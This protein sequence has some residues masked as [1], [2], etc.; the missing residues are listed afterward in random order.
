MAQ[1]SSHDPRSVAL[2]NLLGIG[3]CDRSVRVPIPFE[4]FTARSDK[5]AILRVTNTLNPKVNPLF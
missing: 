5:A 4:P 2:A 1:D 3:A